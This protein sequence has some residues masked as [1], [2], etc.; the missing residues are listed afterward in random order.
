MPGKYFVIDTTRCT[1][2]RGCQVACKEWNH[3][4]AGDTR[5]TGSH[6]NPPGLNGQT[7]RLV[8]FAEHPADPGPMVWY[9]FS[10]ACRH[11]LEP[12]CKQEADMLVKDAI[13]IDDNGA[14]VFTERTR[15]LAKDF[16]MVQDACP[17]SIPQLDR[18]SGLLTKCHMC[19]QRVAAGLPPACVKA[20]PSGALNFGNEAQ[21]KELAQ[22]RLAEARRTHGQAARILDQGDVRALYLVVADLASYQQSGP[23]AAER[24]RRA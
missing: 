24:R 8:R 11:C 7:Y 4:A 13:V 22:N 16:E 1:A 3:L 14:V 17:W 2:C 23:P 10:D 21:M 6:Q 18:A 12:P 5:Q 19:H 15:R 20:C 9:F